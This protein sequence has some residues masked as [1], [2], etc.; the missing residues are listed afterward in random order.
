MTQEASPSHFEHPLLCP[1]DQGKSPWGFVVLPLA[2][3]EKLPRR[4]RTSIEGTVNGHAFTATLEP[5]GNKSHWLRIDEALMQAAGI[6]FGDRLHFEIQAVQQEPEPEVP[7]DMLTALQAVPEAWETWL[8]TTT[9]ARVDWVHWATSAKQAKTR[10]KRIHDACDML[11]SG[12]KKV[13]CFDPSGYY[14]KAF[15][16]PQA[17]EPT[18]K[19]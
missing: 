7:E 12:K 14:S 17:V 19:I 16:A 1:K 18:L 4:G 2:V 10:T 3:S 9:L 5:D 11:S 15:K 6:T 13:C 8:D